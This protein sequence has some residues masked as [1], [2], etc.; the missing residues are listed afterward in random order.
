MDEKNEQTATPTKCP[1]C[2]IIF[3]CPACS[4]KMDAIDQ[5]L[6]REGL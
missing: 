5:E 1:D 4:K 2:G 6:E 3:A